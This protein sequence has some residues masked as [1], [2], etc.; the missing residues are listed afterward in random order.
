M[1]T[2]SRDGTGIHFETVGHGP[3]LVLHHGLGEN[4]LSWAR[5]GFLDVLAERFL[6]VLLD[7][8]GHGRSGKP[9]EPAA[10]TL[11]RRVEDVPVAWMETSSTSRFCTS[12]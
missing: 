8:R 1:E 2:P 5:K 6:L 12:E 10:Y 11:E 4:A 3:P 7:A 9:H